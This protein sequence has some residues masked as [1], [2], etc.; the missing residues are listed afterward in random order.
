MTS[1]RR[2]RQH[3]SDPYRNFSYFSKPLSA[4]GSMSPR[5]TLMP[6]VRGVQS[7]AVLHVEAGGLFELLCPIDPSAS[8]VLEDLLS[9]PSC[10]EN[11]PFPSKETL[12]KFSA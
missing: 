1:S 11:K 10:Q 12:I 7:Q 9:C 2:L 8:W 6:A 5:K 3:L 4:G